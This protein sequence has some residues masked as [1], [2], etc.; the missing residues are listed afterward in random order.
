MGAGKTTF[1]RRLEAELAPRV[2]RFTH[3][4]WMH[5]LY[6]ANPP[7]QEFTH[8]YDR[9]DALINQYAQA[10][11]RAGCDVI[12]DKGFWSRRARDS[13]RRLAQSAGAEPRLYWIKTPLEVMRERVRQRT[14]DLPVD[15]LWINAPAFD[16][17][18]ERFE[19]LDNDEQHVLIES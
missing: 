19:P 15:S 17:L 10:A 3:D 18:L 11:L 1:A 16:K 6:G 4:E 8:L 14:A 13:A 7:E 2:L 5:R 9:V 12:L